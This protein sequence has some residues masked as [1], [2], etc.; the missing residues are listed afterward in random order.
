MT[1]L[2]RACRAAEAATTAAIAAPAPPALPAR[3]APGL[4][5][6]VAGVLA[7]GTEAFMLPG[8]LP[9]I[10]TD[11]GLDLA[12]AGRLAAGYGVAYAIGAPLLAVATA[13]LDR[14]AVLLAALGGFALAALAAVLAGSFAGLLGAR[15]LL[16]LAAACY[17]PAASACAVAASPAAARGRAI[18]RVYGGMTLALVLGV[19]LASALAAAAGWRAAFA[20]TLL[21]ALAAAA[22]IATRRNLPPPD[23][24]APGLAARLRPMRDPAVLATLAVT[25]AGVGGS[26]AVYTYLAAALGAAD[27][28]LPARIGLLLLGFG[29]AGVAGNKVAGIA[30]DRGRAGLATVAS[31]GGKAAAFVLLALLAAGAPPANDTTFIATLA[32]L[33]LYG[34]AG[35]MFPPLQ[36]ARLARL[37]PQALA[38]ALSLNASALYLGMAGG[39]LVGG[40]ALR[41]W[42]AASLGLVGAGIELIALGLLALQGRRVTSP[43]RT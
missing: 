15:L 6:L 26:F 34:F 31:L 33:V 29:L 32:T 30:V 9:A 17:F 24:A 16:A 35:W 42:G 10:A 12:Q 13:R 27:A 36:Q 14:R 39:A 2:A 3:P 22:G 18:T 8:L 23:A 38:T 20:L 41:H 4:G 40:L 5:W 7:V 28:G 19:P 43:S 1:P 37:A 11:F 25:L 21:P